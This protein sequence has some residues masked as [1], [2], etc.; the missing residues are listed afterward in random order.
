MI[1]DVSIAHT[2]QSEQK[3]LLGAPALAIEVF[4]QSDTASVPNRRVKKYLENGAIEVWLVYPETA[5]VSIYRGKTAE[6]EGALSS[7]LLPGEAIGLSKIFC[8]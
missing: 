6:V 2:G 5:T 8:A 4:S 3:F 7:E 1:P